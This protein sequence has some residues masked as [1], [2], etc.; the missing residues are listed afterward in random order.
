M[1]LIKSPHAPQ[2]SS[3][4]VI[5]AA[6]DNFE[7]RLRGLVPLEIRRTIT[8]SFVNSMEPRLF[9]ADNHP[10]RFLQLKRFLLMLQAERSNRCGAVALRSGTL[11]SGE[12][13]PCR[14]RLPKRQFGWDF[15]KL[16]GRLRYEGRLRLDF[17]A[18]NCSARSA[19]ASSVALPFL[20]SQTYRMA[21]RCRSRFCSKKSVTKLRERRCRTCRD[22]FGLA[23][24]LSVLSSRRPERGEPIPWYGAVYHNREIVAGLARKHHHT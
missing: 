20:R 6:T 22:F 21:K 10:P 24:F 17:S 15:E 3:T 14:I 18:L 5:D 4:R 12:I 23:D 2:Y 16:A 11:Q 19:K 9:G 1:I 13:G 8:P 7:R